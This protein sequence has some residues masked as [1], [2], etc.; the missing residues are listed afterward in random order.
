MRI[1]IKIF[2][3]ILL[4][5]CALSKKEISS[6][7]KTSFFLLKIYSAFERKIDPEE[8]YCIIE[9]KKSEILYILNQKYITKYDF[10]D[11]LRLKL[12]AKCVL[13]YGEKYW[14]NSCK[15]HRYNI[16]VISENLTNEKLILSK[17]KNNSNY[18]F[19]FYNVENPLGTSLYVGISNL[20][21]IEFCTIACANYV[22][23]IPEM[24]SIIV[25]KKL[26][27]NPPVFRNRTP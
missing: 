16:S 18:N 26:T 12:N 6:K 7:E 1:I 20:Q 23:R 10:F 8:F 15:A 13:N 3:F 24:D 11:T 9:S 14:E 22:C 5:G 4:I 21:D 27:F 17:I 25:L 19:N 2:F